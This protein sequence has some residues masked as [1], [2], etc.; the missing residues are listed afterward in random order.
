MYPILSVLF[1]LSALAQLRLRTGVP[2]LLRI[3]P[4]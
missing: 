3:V 1:K 2:E 4:Y